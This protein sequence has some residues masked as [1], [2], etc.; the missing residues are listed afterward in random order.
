MKN[1]EHLNPPV[2]RNR[3]EVQ[4][5]PCNPFNEVSIPV[6]NEPNLSAG[7]VRLDRVI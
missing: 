6:F 3:A 5:Y 4:G 1:P 7:S 2:R